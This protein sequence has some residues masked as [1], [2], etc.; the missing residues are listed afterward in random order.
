MSNTSQRSKRY[1]QLESQLKE[2]ILFLD[3]AMGT[4]IQTYNLQEADYRGER[5]K[6]WS[7]DVKGNNDLLSISQPQ[8]IK[9]IHSQ[10][11]EAGA[12]REPVRFLLVS[13]KPLN[14]PIA[15]YGPF[16]MNTQE[17]VQQALEDLRNG[18]FVMR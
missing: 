3:G 12:D 5:F 8:I 15:R 7:C 1:S 14:E 11:I 10:Y 9:S 17:E 2:R 6:D 18:T 4:M 13:G 16:V